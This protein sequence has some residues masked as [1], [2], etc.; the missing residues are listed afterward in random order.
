MDSLNATILRLLDDHQL[1]RAWADWVVP[2]AAASTALVVGLGIVWHNSGNDNDR[3]PPIVPSWIPWWGSESAL[4]RDPDAFFKAAQKHYPD[5]LFGVKTAGTTL[6]YVTSASLINQIYK[7]PKVFTISVVQ[8]SWGKNCFS[9]S[10]DVLRKSSTFREEL[11]PS[12]HRNIAPKNMMPLVQSF[13]RNI[14]RVV[15]EYQVPTGSVSLEEFV[16]RLAHRATSVTWYGPTLNIEEFYDDWNTFD[17]GVWKVAL[18]YPTWLCR[19]FLSARARVRQ[20]IWEYMNKPHEAA[21]QLVQDR[22]AIVRNADFSEHDLGVSLMTPY[23]PL[24]ANVPWASLWLLI[25]QIQRSEGLA[26]I[27]AELDAAGEAW[28]AANP[29]FSGPYTDHLP[30]FFQSQ[31]HIPLLTSTISETLRFTSD[32]YSMRGVLEDTLLSGYT[33]KKGDTLVC[34]TRRVHRDE[35][36][37]EQAEEFVP[38]RFIGKDG[39]GTETEYNYMPFGGGVSMCSGRFFAYYHIKIFLTTV[40][41]NFKLEV[42]EGRSTP[43]VQSGVNRG[44][45]LRRPKGQLYVKVSRI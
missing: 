38:T 31:P 42:D 35:N 43:V 37:F 12:D 44:F 19:P 39:K 45:G 34:L 21:C 26:P 10:D 36:E 8:L 24:M 2:A 18:M 6:Y 25:L 9:W 30:E 23:W 16:M 28:S 20:R 17:R 32:S 14:S 40:L 41:K 11:L 15:K 13:A 27:I 7:Q 22:E 4:E 5:G 1:P 33:I 3:R 29:E